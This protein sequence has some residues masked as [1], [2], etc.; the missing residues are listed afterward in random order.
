MASI[1]NAT[2]SSGVAVSGDTSGVLQ[3]ATNGGTTAVTIDTSQNVGIGTT[4]PSYKLNVLRSGN[5][6]S[7][8]FSN[9]TSTLSVYNG[10]TTA[11]VGDVATNNTIGFDAASN[12]INLL[13]NNTE[14]MRISSAGNVGIG[15]SSPADTSGFGQCI[16]GNSSTGF[17]YYARQAGS[18]TNFFVTGISNSNGILSLAN[19]TG[20]MAFYTNAGSERM[21]IK[22]DGSILT[23]ATSVTG[24]ATGSAVNPGFIMTDGGTKGICTS[25]ENTDANF[26]M[27]KASGYS[28]GIYVRFYVNNSQIGKIETNGSSTSYVT[29]SDYRLKEDIAPM[30]GALAKVALLKPVTY[31]WKSDGSAGEG[32]V[33][34][35]LAEVCPDAVSGKKDAL[36]KDGDIEPQGIDTSFLVATLTAAIQEQQALI[37]T[38]QTQ[39][40]ELKQKVGA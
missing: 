19:T 26:Y 24:L 2:T 29:S 32:F 27:S 22:S 7:A 21:R 11:Y 17:G 20:Y 1:I 28:S 18:S 35:E 13:T 9:G 16:D 6:Y 36:N 12:Y 23:G 34:H 25:Q 8:Q 37:T 39:V 31:K 38:L 33:A 15:T 10:A 5:G 30:T 40:A 4:S 3:L 14:R